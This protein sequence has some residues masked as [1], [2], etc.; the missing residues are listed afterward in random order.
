MFET[1]KNRNLPPIVF[2]DIPMADGSMMSVHELRERFFTSEYG[3][4]MYTQELRY[5]GRYGYDREMMKQDLGE[6]V[7]PVGHQYEV[8]EHLQ[9]TLDSEE[10]A[11]SLVQLSDEEKAIVAFAC[12][13]HDIGE[14]EHSDLAAAG[15]TTVGDI[16]AGNKTDADRINEAAVRQFFY[17]RFYDDVDPAIIERVEAI[18]AH[19]D[20][21]ILHELFEV[22]HEI[23]TLD[24]V[25]RA[26]KALRAPYL[27]STQLTALAGLVHGV[28]KFHES[29]LAS[30]EYFTVI[31]NALAAS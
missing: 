25:A 2:L 15:I 8:T 27:E 29:K 12:S 20:D 6:D 7:C 21:T 26:E 1:I 19:R 31:K 4:H 22:A 24:T 5:A 11:G 17:A 9:H 13:I 28:P 23:Q 3:V 18:I 30:L 14:C 16:P 10:A